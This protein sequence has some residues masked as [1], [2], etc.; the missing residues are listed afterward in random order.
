MSKRN[1]DNNVSDK[2]YKKH[3][4]KSYRRKQNKKNAL[5]LV[6]NISGIFVSCN[7]KKESL[8]VSECYDLFNEYADKIYTANE[9][10]DN[11]GSDNEGSDNDVE[12]S[13]AKEIAQMKE[14][15]KSRRFMSIPT[16]TDCVVF[17]KT[18]PPVNP[19][20]LVHSI[21][22]DLYN[23]GKKK[24]R[25]S[26]R[27]IPITKTCYANM[28]DIKK[29]AEE[30]LKP[31]FHSLKD[32]QQIQYAIVP[33]FRNNNV[34]D[35]MELINAIAELVGNQHKV[36]LDDPK[37]VIIVD[38]FMNICGMSI[39]EDYK[40]LKKYNIEKIFEELNKKESEETDLIRT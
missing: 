37:L 18:N 5:I 19:I 14:S 20:E 32:N 4:V 17:I 12:S 11:E 22:I 33:N 29:M 6:P 24:T 30:I 15:H 26:M 8:C 1:R 23:T 13:I 9:G 38:V 7:Q 39:L 28:N 40:K 36:N 2:S 35:R 21:L 25:F 10:S 34:I 3:K 27:M 31:R 16:G